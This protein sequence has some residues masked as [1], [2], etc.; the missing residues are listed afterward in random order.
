MARSG[1]NGQN[2][3]GLAAVIRRRVSNATQ[4]EA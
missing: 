1:S 3:V 4:F 2:V